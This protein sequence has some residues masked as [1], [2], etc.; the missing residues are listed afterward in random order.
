MSKPALIRAGAWRV[1]RETVKE[2]LQDDL[3][4]YAS[5]I[6]F[7]ALLSLFPFLLFLAALLGFL[8]LDSFFAWLQ[9]SATAMLPEEAAGLVNGI[10]AGL[11]EQKRGLLSFGIATA[12]WVA[13][14]GVRMIMKAMNVAYEVP[15]ARSPWKRYPLSIF[16][17]LGLAAMTIAAAALLVVGPQ[18]MEWIAGQVGLGDMFV[19]VWSWLRW[20]VAVL[21]LVVAVA[22]IYYAAPNVDHPFKLFTPGALVAV[23]V[24]IA[25]SV[26]FGYYVRHF[27]DYDAMY[28]S[29][30][31][32]IILLFYLYISA[33]VLLFGAEMNAVIERGSTGIQPAQQPAEERSPARPAF[34]RSRPRRSAAHDPRE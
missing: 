4:T 19:V 32:V 12:L 5:A 33:A 34:S 29:I 13:S 2:Y 22:V 8:H 25:G 21:L 28:G 14:A 10:V 23:A 20:P 31:A 26:G 18:A 3:L 16:Y 7:Q 17:T 1:T 6:A 11:Q 27:A 30:G 24:W 15:E 9:R